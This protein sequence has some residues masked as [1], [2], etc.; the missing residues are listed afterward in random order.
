VAQG[1]S[2][3]ERGNVKK[4]RHRAV[5][6]LVAGA[7]V[8]GLT[9]LATIFPFQVVRHAGD[10]MEPT[11]SNQQ[12][13]IV[14][15]LSFRLRDPRSG[16]IVMMYYPLDPDRSFVRRLIAREGDTVKLAGG[17]VFIN[18]MPLREAYAPA[19][20][21]SRADWG[22]QVVPQGYYFVLGDRRNG[23]SDSRHW[24]FV[25]KRYITGTII[26]RFG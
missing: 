23:R 12:L 13:V 11:L 20:F 18:D 9:I 1:F 17:I 4:R 26:A 22:P 25:P 19:E 2:P 6:P 7:V 8:L 15:K 10:A 24:G 14:N 16:D 3:V 5:I 21:R